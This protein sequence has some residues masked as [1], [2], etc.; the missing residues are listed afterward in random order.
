MTLEEEITQT[1]Q[2]GN[3]S[4]F[5]FH[6]FYHY[7]NNFRNKIRINNANKSYIVA[8]P[9]SASAVVFASYDGESVINTHHDKPFRR[10]QLA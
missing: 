1:L 2:I 7:A 3:M 4:A 9:L 10:P 8:T 5:Q 6:I